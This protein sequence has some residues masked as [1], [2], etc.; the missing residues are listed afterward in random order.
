MSIEERARAARRSETPITDH[1]KGDTRPLADRLRSVGL[2]TPD[3][4][5]AIRETTYKYAR[6]I[7]EGQL[8]IMVGEP[9]SGK[10]TVAEWLAGQMDGEVL[11]LN[12]DIS[13]GHIPE[14]KRRA[15]RGGY[16]LI[17]PDLLNEGGV[18]QILGELRQEA[19]RGGDL[20]DLT[21]II[22]TLKKLGEMVSKKSLPD[23]MRTLRSLTT[24]GATVLCLGHTNKYELGEGKHQ[25]PVYEGTA[26]LRSDCDAMVALIGYRGD[27][28][29]VTTSLYAKEQGWP[30]AK[31]RGVIEPL[32][33]RIDPHEGR[34]VELLDEWVD[35]QKLVRE[36]KDVKRHADL[37]QD[38]HSWLN[39]Q[40][41][42]ANQSQIIEALKADHNHKPVR[43]CL[44]KYEGKFWDVT[45]LRQ[46]NAKHFK[47]IQGV[48]LPKA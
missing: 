38:I 2:V 21:I 41:E 42:G 29:V 24:K 25:W 6:T 32:T 46:D 39:A 20:S 27:Y 30:H 9:N 1:G 3:V 19:E 17:C 48:K 8:I 35:T 33:W 34:T 26:D 5:Q 15:D 28:G 14:A 47:A 43:R 7:P 31:D 11:Y 36:A 10:T 12:M 18:P 45:R 44:D 16:D 23:L 40:P 4:V 22:D 13:S 37:I